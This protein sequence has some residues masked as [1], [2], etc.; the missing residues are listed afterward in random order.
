MKI[1]N[2]D[3]KVLGDILDI[4]HGKY[5]A[6]LSHSGSRN[7]GEENTNCNVSVDKKRDVIVAKMKK[8]DWSTNP[9]KQL[10]I[11]R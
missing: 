3:L 7:M 9:Y 10:L 11:R 8:D 6:V 4:P 5:L 1:T 2:K